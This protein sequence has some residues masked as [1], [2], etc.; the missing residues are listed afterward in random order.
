MNTATYIPGVRHPTSYVLRIR[1]GYEYGTMEPNRSARGKDFSSA[2]MPRVVNR[3]V[4]AG[5]AKTL[6]AAEDQAAQLRMEA[7]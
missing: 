4:K 3:R 5:T 6:E 1:G 7:S 2:A